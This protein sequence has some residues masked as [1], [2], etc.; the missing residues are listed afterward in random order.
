MREGVTRPRPVFVAAA[1]AGGRAGEQGVDD[2]EEDEPRQ[3]SRSP[4]LPQ[5][6]EVHVVKL[7]SKVSP[8]T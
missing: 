7:R 6:L 3:T 2:L 5:P 8:K 1:K 4:A